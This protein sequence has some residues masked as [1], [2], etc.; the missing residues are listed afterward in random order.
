MRSILAAVCMCLIFSGCAGRTVYVKRP[1]P[2]LHT[3]H[4]DAPKGLRYEV[5]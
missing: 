1:C 3:L 2:Q 5:R 4:V